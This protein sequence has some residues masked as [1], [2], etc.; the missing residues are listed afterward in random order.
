MVPAPLVLRVFGPGDSDECHKCESAEDDEQT[1]VNEN[2]DEQK[3]PDHF[4]PWESVK[5]MLQND[6]VNSAISWV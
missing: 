1:I 6:L 4:A 5:H 3:L 2:S